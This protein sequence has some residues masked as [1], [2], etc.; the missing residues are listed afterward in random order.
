MLIFDCVENITENIL[1]IFSE[2]T[3]L[4]LRPVQV[5]GSELSKWRMIFQARAGQWIVKGKGGQGQGRYVQQMSQCCI[6][7]FYEI[8]SDRLCS[9]TFDRKTKVHGPTSHILSKCWSW[10]LKG[11]GGGRG[12]AGEGTGQMLLQLHSLECGEFLQERLERSCNGHQTLPRS[13]CTESL[14]SLL[15]LIFSFHYKSERALQCCADTV[16][17]YLKE[18][19]AKHGENLQFKILIH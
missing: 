18:V 7:E 14:L 6:S 3:G 17:R 11:G 1:E 19:R 8:L 10:I 15:S 9:R 16:C 2:G 13:V 4:S 5:S 12:A